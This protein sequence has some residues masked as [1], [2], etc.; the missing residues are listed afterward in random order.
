MNDR[1]SL[2]DDSLTTAAIGLAQA[3]RLLADGGSHRPSGWI[4]SLSD[5]GG[6][7]DAFLLSV[8]VARDALADAA[9]S[10]SHAASALM[11]DSSEL[12]A[13]LAATL[14]SGF[15]MNDEVK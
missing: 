8:N 15:A 9:K 12:D 4:P 14:Y 5:I 3:A 7:V 6:E 10:A 11:R 1:L 13:K 2:S